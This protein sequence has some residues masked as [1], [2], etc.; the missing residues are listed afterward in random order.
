MSKSKK[1]KGSIT[2]GEV[3]VSSIASSFVGQLK[4]HKKLFVHPVKEEA[5]RVLDVPHSFTGYRYTNKRNVMLL[6]MHQLANPEWGSGYATSS[7]VR[8]KGGHIKSDELKKGIPIESNFQMY[9]DEDGKSH[10]YPYSDKKKVQEIKDKGL[11]TYWVNRY[12]TVF[13]IVGQTEGM[14]AKY[15]P[16]PTLFDRNCP[17]LAADVAQKVNDLCEL[18]GVKVYHKDGVPC[19]VHGRD[20][21]EIP[22][23][24]KFKKGE[25][26]YYSTLLHELVHAVGTTKKLNF[27]GEMKPRN[28]KD[29]AVE[30]L[31]AE[32]GSVMM[33]AQLGIPYEEHVD[34]HAGYIQLWIDSIEADPSMLMNSVQDVVLSS[35]YLLNMTEESKFMLQHCDVDEQVHLYSMA[36]ATGKDIESC[37]ENM[38]NGKFPKIMHD[39]SDHHAWHIAKSCEDNPLSPKLGKFTGAIESEVKERVVKGY[40]QKSRKLAKSMMLSLDSDY[41]IDSVSDASLDEGM[42]CS[43]ALSDDGPSPTLGA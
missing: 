23:P 18:H 33:C 40:H 11:Y 26:G 20:H 7:Q 24:H 22:E 5:L 14:P 16:K 36:V 27:K 3:I 29:R 13:N 17:K 35:D 43:Q 10:Y 4:T 21:I 9:T 31:R 39:L 19:Y 2:P 42:D 15:Y 25:I 37:I 41:G 28:L 32:L 34:N 1:A 12:K 38:S 8:K 30:E 6:L